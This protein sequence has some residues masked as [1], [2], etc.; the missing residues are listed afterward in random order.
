MTTHAQHTPG[1]W[2][3]GESRDHYFEGADVNDGRRVIWGP[4]GMEVCLV[5][6]RGGMTAA[7]ARLIAAAPRMLEF[8]TEIAAR[9]YVANQIAVARAILREIE[10]QRPNVEGES[11]G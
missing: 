3:M 6:D 4:D 5:R 10:G 1:P 11:N 8:I 2:E 7:N 9:G